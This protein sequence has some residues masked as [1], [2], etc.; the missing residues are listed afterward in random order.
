VVYRKL[1]NREGN[2]HVAH[3]V[4]LIKELRDGLLGLVDLS[5]WSIKGIERL[6]PG[7][8]ETKSTDDPFI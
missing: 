4:T 7:K 8:K 5:K 2:C 1:K 3:P 6:I